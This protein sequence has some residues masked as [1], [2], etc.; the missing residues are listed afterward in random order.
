MLLEVRI[1]N[2]RS[3]EKEQVFSML[4]CDNNKTNLDP[5]SG[6]VEECDGYKFGIN[7][8]IFN[9]GR[10][11]IEVRKTATIYGANGSGKTNFILAMS[12]IQR[13]L[14]H[15]GDENKGV[16]IDWSF[17]QSKKP[18]TIVWSFILPNSQE[19]FHYKI[20]L[21]IGTILL[22]ELKNANNEVIFSRKYDKKTKNYRYDMP[23]QQIPK[24]LT[25]KVA[26]AS[27]KANLQ[28]QS[29][30]NQRLVEDSLVFNMLEVS[31]AIT[32]QQT[33]FVQTC[34]VRQSIEKM[35]EIVHFFNPLKFVLRAP[36]LNYHD[37]NLYYSDLN[38]SLINMYA[39]DELQSKQ[40]TVN[41]RLVQNSNTFSKYRTI[42]EQI[43]A[44]DIDHWSYK[45]RNDGTYEFYSYKNYN[46]KTYKYD[47]YNHESSG[48]KRFACYYGVLHLLEQNGGGVLLI[49]ELDAHFHPLLI[50]E[51]L[52]YVNNK[53]LPIQ[54]IAT[55]HNTAVLRKSILELDQIHFVEKNDQA[56]EIY[57][58]ADFDSITN[59][60]QENLESTYLK[61]SF[62]AIPHI[63][64]LDFCS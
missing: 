14:G 7:S 13:L 12:L 43:G 9:Q 10:S 55:L 31:K 20:Q 41:N 18:S 54:I 63:D 21:A 38:G 2:F 22:E 46:G 27:M 61:G 64:Y 40:N 57:S 33:L 45:K 52:E 26:V 53:N 4:T 8:V 44:G 39:E 49:D 17:F 25:S 24:Y 34:G 1:K 3:I 36:I 62:G 50:I 29:E 47:L 5:E 16:T 23:A 42:F 56:S 51:L 48:T 35:Q 37:V 11:C 28:N 60:E 58:L 15:W 32:D 30:E 59:Y 6:N 19:I